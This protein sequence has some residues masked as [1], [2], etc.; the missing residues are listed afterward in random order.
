[1]LRIIKGIM[2]LK[3]EFKKALSGHLNVNQNHLHDIDYEKIVKSLSSSY[4]CWIDPKNI[5][6]GSDYKVLLYFAI[7]E[8][9]RLN[10]L[11]QLIK[12]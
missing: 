4:Q 12:D 10:Y 6:N 5:W 7:E 9:K 8:I 2:K 11:I 3:K 1:M